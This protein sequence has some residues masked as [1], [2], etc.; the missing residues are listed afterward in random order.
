LQSQ[1][2]DVILAPDDGVGAA[3]QLLQCHHKRLLC[4]DTQAM[5]ALQHLQ[6][7]F[8]TQQ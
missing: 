4:C 7:T 2:Q 5:H 8:D 1:Q 3:W 6:N